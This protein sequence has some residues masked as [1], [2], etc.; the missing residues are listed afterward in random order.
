M[1]TSKS[2]E[3]NT[4]SCHIV[5]AAN[6]LRVSVFIKESVSFL[7]TLKVIIKLCRRKSDFGRK[8]VFSNS[9][10]PAHPPENQLVHPSDEDF[11]VQRTGDNA[12]ALSAQLL[13][14]F[15]LNTLIVSYISNKKDGG[16]YCVRFWG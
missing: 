15:W 14:Y 3:T 9:I 2:I 6:N 11:S 12:K 16:R 7:S 13:K 1:N 10:A 5:S 4:Y 8:K